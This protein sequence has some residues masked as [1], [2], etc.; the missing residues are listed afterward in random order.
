M[1]DELYQDIPSRVIEYLS[2]EKEGNP[3]AEHLYEAYGQVTAESNVVILGFPSQDEN[4]NA[5]S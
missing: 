1:G 5:G 2:N 4:H 3:L